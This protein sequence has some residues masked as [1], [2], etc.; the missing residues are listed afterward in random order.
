MLLRKNLKERIAHPAIREALFIASPDLYESLPFWIRDPE[1]ERGQKIEGALTRY[2][3]RMTSRSTPFGLF[4]GYSLGKID[5]ESCLLLKE[6]QHYRRHTRLD[7]GYLAALCEDLKRSKTLQRSL[8]YHPNTSLYFSGGRARY[9]ETRLQEKARTYFLVAVDDSP[10]LRAALECA[11][12]D[13]GYSEIVAAILKS[14]AE[15]QIK[16]AESYVDELIQNQVVVTR[17]EPAATGDEPIQWLIRKLKEIPLAQTTLV[18]LEKASMSLDQ[19]DARGLGIDPVEYQAIAK[20]LEI[21]ETKTE[22]SH[23][24]QVDMIKSAPRLT[25]G[26][27]IVGELI[28]A[29]NLMHRIHQSRSILLR[30]FQEAFVD[31]YQDREVP[32]MNVLDE[33]SGIGLGQGWRHAFQPQEPMATWNRLHQILASKL[34]DSARRH[35][36]EIVL[37]EKDLKKLENT[38]GRSTYPLPDTFSVKCTLSAASEQ[39]LNEGD[40]QIFIS[41]IEGPSGAAM[42]GRFCHGDRELYQKVKEHLTTEASFNTEAVYAEIVHLPQG[43]LGNILC[44]PLLRD[45]EITYLGLSGAMPENQILMTDLMVSVKGNQIILRSRRLGREVIPRLSSAHN[46]SNPRNLLPYRFLSMLQFQGLSRSL[47]MDWGVLDNLPFLPRIRIGRFILK[48]AQWTIQSEEWKDHLKKNEEDLFLYIRQWRREREIP[49]FVVI[50]EHDNELLIDFEN[51]LSIQNFIDLINIR[52]VIQLIEQFPELDRLCVRGSEGRFTHE[53][54]IPFHHSALKAKPSSAILPLPD[55]NYDKSIP[56]RSL[57]PG[58]EVLYLE[59][60]AG[61]AIADQILCHNILPMA[62]ELMQSGTIEGWFFIRYTDP[63][64]HLRL[65]F[66]GDPKR[67]PSQVLPEIHQ[68]MKPLLQDGRLWRIRCNTYEREMERYGGSNGIL[69]SENLFCIDSEAVAM[70][71]ESILGDGLEEL[72]VPMAMRGADCLLAD[73]G[74]NI[75][76]RRELIQKIL[77]PKNAPVNYDRKIPLHLPHFSE[78]FRKQRKAVEEALASN[79]RAESPFRHGA[80]IFE[81]RSQKLAPVVQA[82]LQ[83]DR[84]KRLTKTIPELLQSYLHMHVNR[85]L[86]DQAFAK[87]PMIYDFLA[88]YYESIL[89][90]T[91]KPRVNDRVP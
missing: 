4:A 58:S 57:L 26:S 77:R 14:D 25:L 49:R 64:F 43:R 19:L 53:L 32:L 31:R 21:L 20:D 56:E 29:V 3:S 84:E 68:V 23:L 70:C 75:L 44:R 74:L 80:L 88:R 6:K 18:A 55:I 47:G 59:L 63:Q 9:V 73:F 79:I 52:P 30:D 12:N 85:V 10:Y 35:D 38:E 2:F 89:A 66:F 78:P 90:R 45:F 13:S 65:R 40:F 62:K 16:E 37:E 28:Q 60:Y 71:L 76:A 81:S 51:I 87:E 34:I 91:K 82:I 50:A 36:H 15:I 22:L 48:R 41:G 7:N 5:A 67:L 33:E 27:N 24:F 39:K 54:I 46:F 11:R 17:L 8:K 42:L 72:R 86:R 61:S 1:S 69:L 83:L